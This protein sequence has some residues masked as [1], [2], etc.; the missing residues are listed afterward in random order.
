MSCPRCGKVFSN[1]GNLNY[2]IKNAKYCLNREEKEQTFNCQFCDKILSSKQRLSD[3]ENIC[4]SKLKSDY[5][6][7]ISKLE[8]IIDQGREREKMSEIRHLDEI[9]HI[10][11]ECQEK[12]DDL[13][14][15]VRDLQNKLFELASRPTNTT[16]NNTNNNNNKIFANLQ[17]VSADHLNDQ[18]RHLTIDHIKK[19]AIG[20]SEFFLDHSLKDRIV[21]TDYARR[22]IKYKNEDGDIVVDPE[23][24]NLSDQLFQSI[25][26]R[27]KE[28]SEKYLTELTNKFKGASDSLQ[29]EYF[30]E[31]ASKFSEQDIEV[32]KMI[33]GEKNNMYHDII[34]YLCSRTVV[35]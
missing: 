3:H 24:S 35:S 13:K 9:K 30:M 28:L 6:L 19:G 29:L 20:Y 8:T 12:I 2:H 22:K 15:Q 21:C 10:K 17:V 7:E 27:N 33:N 18:A 23:M 34:R 16:T 4:T 14:N 25:K 5:E 31:V 1:K 32:V 26:S 11:N